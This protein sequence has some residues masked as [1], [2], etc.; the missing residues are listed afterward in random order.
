MSIIVKSG[1]PG[2]VPTSN[3]LDY[4]QLAI[5]YAD[6]RIYFK[7]SANQLTRIPAIS[8]NADGYN[9]DAGAVRMT[10]WIGPYSTIQFGTATVYSALSPVNGTGFAC[11]GYFDTAWKYQSSTGGATV[12]SPGNGGLSLRLAPPGTV[13]TPITWNVVLNTAGYNHLLLGLG[14]VQASTQTGTTLSNGLAISENSGNIKIVERTGYNHGATNSVQIDISGGLDGCTYL[15]EINMAAYL[16]K[17]AKFQ[18]QVYKANTWTDYGPATIQNIV[19]AGISLAYT[20][21]VA[22]TL[23]YTISGMAG[24]EIVVTNVK[25]IVGTSSPVGSPT[26]TFTYA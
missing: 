20:S 10:P 12:L 21:P 8:I 4:G 6:Q 23:R 2:K 1:V 25:I 13:D 15:I 7:N 11:N 24:A 3:Q 26:F 14:A 5:N 9:V 19:S 18:H 22:G 16:G 17:Y